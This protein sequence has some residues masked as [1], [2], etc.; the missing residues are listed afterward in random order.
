MLN[1]VHSWWWP[2]PVPYRTIF[3]WVVCNVWHMCETA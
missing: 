1:I 3:W 2:I